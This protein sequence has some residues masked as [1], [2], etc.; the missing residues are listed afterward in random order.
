MFKL[1]ISTIILLFISSSKIISADIATQDTSKVIIDCNYTFKESIAGIDIP[2]KIKENLKLINVQYYSFDGKIH[3]GQLLIHKDLVKDV[4]EIFKSIM[5]VKFPIAKVIPV[6]KYGWNDEKSM[7]DNNTSAFNYRIVAN[8]KALSSHSSGRAIDINPKLNPQ[9]KRNHYFPRGS[10]YEPTRKGT[11][12][13]NSLLVKEFLK[14]GWMWG[15]LWHS[16]KD[17][18]HFEKK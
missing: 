9:I 7:K 10:K 5:S 12:T 4:E 2:K 11:I 13:K 1:F 6:V 3:Q 14:H 16:T 15:G 18:Q 8:T 17:Y